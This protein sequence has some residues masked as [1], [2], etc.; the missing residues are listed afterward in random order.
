M[1]TRF[2]QGSP[3]DY[4]GRVDNALPPAG[5]VGEFPSGMSA[6]AGT[7]GS[8]YRTYSTTIAGTSDTTLVT[9]TLNKG[10]YIIGFNI[11]ST[12]AVDATTPEF[13][14]QVRVGGTGVGVALNIA[15][16]SLSASYISGARIYPSLITAD[17]TAIT[18]VG[19]QTVA[20]ARATF[21]DLWA[22]RI[23]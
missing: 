1:S 20:A 22:I 12:K 21:T 6:Q 23:G 7:N 13:T 16:T 8:I 17:G 5:Y 2:I 9:L 10:L 4:Q 15:Y 18:V 14:A 19:S 3:V 11:A